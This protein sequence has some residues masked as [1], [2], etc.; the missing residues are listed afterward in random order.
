MSEKNTPARPLCLGPLIDGSNPFMSYSR[1]ILPLATL[2]LLPILV[3]FFFSQKYFVEGVN[4]SAV[5]G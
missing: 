2:V 4:S 3:L 1:T 5:K